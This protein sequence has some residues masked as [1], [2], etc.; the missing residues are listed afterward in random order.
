MDFRKP[1][2]VQHRS[3]VLEHQCC[4]ECGAEVLE[5]YRTHDRAGVCLWVECVRPGCVNHELIA[6]PVVSR[7]RAQEEALRMPRLRGQLRALHSC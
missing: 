2:G 4:W 3:S 7:R 1:L 5:V 6:L